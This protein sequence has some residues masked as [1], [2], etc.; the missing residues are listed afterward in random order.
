M[1]GD[2]S[3]PSPSRAGLRADEYTTVREAAAAARHHLSSLA[4][5]A[6]GASVILCVENMP[7]GVFPGSR[8]ADLEA[9]VDEV[10]HPNVKICFDMYHLQLMEGNIA[11][12][13]K[14]G[15]AK[16]WIG[17]VQIGEVPGRKEPRT[18]EIDFAYIFR[19][20]RG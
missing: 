6:A 8:M 5:D 16:G 10:A 1:K 13:L 15:L 20:L 14:Q 4:D 19:V 12:H 9:I 11:T 17:L 2:P 7:P 3:S 18:G